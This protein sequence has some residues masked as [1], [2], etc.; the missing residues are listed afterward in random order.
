MQKLLLRQRAELEM[1]LARPGTDFANAK[2]D[3]VQI[4]TSVTV[5]DMATR[6]AIHSSHLGAWDSD[7][8]RNIISY[9]ADWRRLF[10]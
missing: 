7:P 3:T 4:G 1:M 2:T 9:P 6:P 10:K 5:A 8:A